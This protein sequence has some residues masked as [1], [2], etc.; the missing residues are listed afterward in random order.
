MGTCWLG[1]TLILPDFVLP[2]RINQ[3]REYSGMDSWEGCQDKTHFRQY[4]HVVNYHYNSRGYRDQEWSESITD[5]KNSIW[6]V[7]D[8]FTVGL[9]SP[10]EHTWPWLLQKQT[11]Q[12]AINVSMDGASNNWISRKVLKVLSEIQPKIIVVQWSYLFRDENPNTALDDEQRRQQYSDQTLS[13]SRAQLLERFIQLVNTVKQAQT[14]TVI[15]HSFVPEFYFSTTAADEWRKFAGVG[16]PQLPKDSESFAELPSNVHNE[17]KMFEQHD[18][19]C[20]YAELLSTMQ[21]YVD[22]FAKQDLA[23]DGHHYDLLTATG[24]VN[25]VCEKLHHRTV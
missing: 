11:G 5:L 8:S 24:F 10:V 16:W 23:R 17:L 22:E 14:N 4:P 21:V 25:A 15:V 13:L 9:G 18:V 2:S 19:F 3:R 20:L 1:P 6:C 7:G 12:R